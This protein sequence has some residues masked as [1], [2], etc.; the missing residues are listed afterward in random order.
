[1]KKGLVAL[2]ATVMLITV[3]LSAIPLTSSAAGEFKKALSIIEGKEYLILSSTTINDKGGKSY[4][5][6]LVKSVQ[7]DDPHG[8]GYGNKPS[9]PYSKDALWIFE[10][11]GNDQYYMKS[12]ST[13][14]YLNIKSASGAHGYASMETTKQA[15]DVTYS[16]TWKITATL[17]GT[18]WCI[19]FTNAHGASVWEAG[20]ATNSNTFNFFCEGGA[21]AAAPKAEKEYN[22]TT[23]PLFKVVT[24]G[25]P[26]VDYGIQSWATPIRQ[27]SISS[28]Q[29]VKNTLGGADIAIVAG[30]MTSKNDTN[31]AWNK[32]M[33][34]R[35][36]TTMFDTFASATNSGKVLFVAGNHENE[37]GINSDNSW[38]SGDWS[39]IM[40]QRNGAFTAEYHFNDMGNGTSKFN[41]QLCYRYTVGKM[42][43]IGINTPYRTTRSSGYI[44]VKQVEWVENQLKAIGKDKTVIILCHYPLDNIDTAPGDTAGAARI[45]MKSVLDSYPNAIW[46]YGH[47][48]GDDHK[49]TWV[50]TS[51]LVKPSASVTWTNKNAVVTN[52]YINAHCG[53]MAYYYNMFNNYQYLGAAEPGINQLLMMEFYTDHITFRYYNTGEKTAIEGVREIAS[54]TVMRDMS[55]QLGGSG[56]DGKYTAASGGGSTPP[57]TNVTPGTSSGSNSSSNKPGT[58]GTNDT[59][60]IT[61]TVDTGNT[62]TVDPNLSDSQ[63]IAPNTNLPSDSGNDGDSNLPTSGN[64]DGDPSQDKDGIPGWAIG[65]LIASGVVVL[66]AAGVAVW[67]VVFKKQS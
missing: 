45:K 18:V 60:D 63:V 44:Y 48:H 42:E 50:N 2:L 3:I 16:S 4:P 39:D 32:Y 24:F 59:T 34:N 67:F 21:A 9:A 49:F 40:T 17:G 36:Q 46:A 52:G 8:L 5:E 37:A 35:V 61:D 1:M 43:F 14:L 30:D 7:G 19:R 27:S 53:S 51:E 29:F 41:E 20:S 31:A 58:S 6:C 11:A 56:W 55:A 10:D 57:T 54:Y 22:N 62:D 23:E 64:T 13:G 38:Y 33:F 66:A 65:V 12:A 28:A 25:D 47:V 26:H 15:L